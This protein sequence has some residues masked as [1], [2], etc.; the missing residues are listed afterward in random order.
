M[1][2]ESEPQDEEVDLMPSA[3]QVTVQSP[4]PPA[5]ELAPNEE[6]DILPLDDDLVTDVYNLS[7]NELQE[8][9]VQTQRKHFPNDHASPA[10]IGEKVIVQD[11]SKNPNAIVE[12]NLTVTGAA[13]SNT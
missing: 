7:H 11:T 10:F 3:P 1:E 6:G 9:I 5:I 4:P 8:R 2:S 12:A 13:R